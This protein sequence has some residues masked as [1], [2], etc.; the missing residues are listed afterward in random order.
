MD[1]DILDY[2][3]LALIF[4]VVIHIFIKTFNVNKCDNKEYMAQSN[5]NTPPV[6]SLSDSKERNGA[7]TPSCKV[8]KMDNDVTKFIHHGNVPRK[9]NLI[10]DEINDDIIEHKLTGCPIS[11]M[12]NKTDTYIRKS[13]LHGSFN[14]VGCDNYEKIDNFSNEQILKYQ[15]DF[16][17]FNDKV[18]YASNEGIDPI[19]KLN[20]MQI[21]DDD[22]TGK[23][24]S[25]VFAELTENKISKIIN[26]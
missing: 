4:I 8:D 7:M 17:G 10:H 12:D 23:R 11:D 21:S 16:F 2:I 3:I 26:F 19:D 9:I 22:S 13:V 18:N 20:E 24:I 6:Q 14:C 1:S 25:D 5:N 15:N